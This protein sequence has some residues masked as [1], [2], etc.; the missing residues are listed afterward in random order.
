MTTQTAND[1]LFQYTDSELVRP[2]PAAL[3]AARSDVLASVQEL[4][5]I[6]DD[7][8]T[9]TWL[10]KGGSEEE[11]RYGFYRIGEAFELAGIEAAAALRRAGS[12]RGPAA[13]RLAQ[14]TAAR[15]DLQGLLIPLADA[16]WDVD[17]GGGEW[18]IR[19]TLGHVVASQRGYGA[20]SGWWQ[21]QALPADM[22]DLP[23]VPESIFDVLPTEEAESYGTPGSVRDRLD[24]ALDR[25][26]ER[27]AGLPEQRLAYGARWSGFPVD[28]GFR[29]GRWASH[30]REHAIQVEKTLDMLDHRPTE[31]DRLIRH[32]LSAWGGAEAVVFGSIDADD[33]VEVLAGAARGARVT[34]AE[35]ASVSQ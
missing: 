18:T 20:T 31:V 2:V 24:D 17:P 15:W 13:D 35:V 11:V 32:V 21:T 1:L 26:C 6:A 10:W 25:S 4:R 9:R 29:M 33:A 12:D 3:V 27:L 7:R 14:A 28:V 23:V 30:I 16:T 34:A 8:L 19:Q 22:P 5:T